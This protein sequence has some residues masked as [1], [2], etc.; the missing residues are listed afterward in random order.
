MAAPPTTTLCI[1]LTNIT[2]TQH[3]AAIQAMR[4]AGIEQAQ[5]VV[6]EEA[7]ARSRTATRAAALLA[8]GA[9]AALLAWVWTGEWRWGPTAGLALVVALGCLG[10]AET[11]RGGGKPGRMAS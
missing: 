4:D 1:T 2:P 10:F 11:R 7:G 8:F 6:S 5:M 3:G 9:V